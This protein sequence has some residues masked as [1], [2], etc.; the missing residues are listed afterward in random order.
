MGYLEL[1]KEIL[2]AN[3][4]GI[5]RSNYF[6]V[7]SMDDYKLFCDRWN[8]ELITDD[9]NPDLVGFL[10]QDS[11]FGG[12]NLNDVY[13]EATGDCVTG[14]FTGELAALL[15]DGEVAVL[16][17]TG[18]EKHNYVVG[19]ALAVHSDGRELNVSIDD[20]Y[21]IIEKEFGAKPTHAAY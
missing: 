11:N 19:W 21:Q 17:E 20:I 14:N 8:L 12:F 16:M 6:R 9:E 1:S 2:M 18:H 5:G 15:Q 13:D 3:Y 7:K 10:D 4:Q